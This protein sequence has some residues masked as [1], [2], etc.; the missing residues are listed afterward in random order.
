MIFDF[1]LETN[2][3]DWIVVNDGVMG[4]V[5]KG[6]IGLNEKG[7]GVFSGNVSLENNGGFSSVRYRNVWSSL[8]D[9]TSF[10]IRLKGDGKSYQ[11]RAKAQSSDFFSY[12]KTFSTTGEW[13]EVIVPFNE[14]T[15]VFRGRVLNQPTLKGD[16][17]SEVGFLIGNKKQENFQLI[18]DKIILK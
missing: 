2:I 1:N 18:I 17:L 9:Y 5:S 3:S 6:Q 16:Q 15:P 11:F 4:G 8:N 7:D 13:Q 10:V 14:M 12:R